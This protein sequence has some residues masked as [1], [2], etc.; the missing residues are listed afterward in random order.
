MTVLEKYGSQ[1]A[2]VTSKIDASGDLV[3]RVP[4]ARMRVRAVCP[5]FMPIRTNPNNRRKPGQAENVVKLGNPGRLR[6]VFDLD[7]FALQEYSP[8][9]LIPARFQ[10]CRTSFLNGRLRLDGN[11]L[12]PPKNVGQPNISRDRPFANI[13]I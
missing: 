3:A 10:S 12:V 1:Q 11:S 7:P 13:S 2:T 9:P 4:I 8:P 6:A 5:G